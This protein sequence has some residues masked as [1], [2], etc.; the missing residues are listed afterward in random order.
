MEVDR[1]SV[2]YGGLVAVNELSFTA[3]EEQVT[4]VLGPNGAGKTS[5]IE[6]LEGFRQPSSGTVRVSGLDPR[7]DRAQLNRVIGVMLQGG[8]LYTAIRPLEALQL[9]ASYYDSPRDPAEL[10]RQVGLA[11]RARTPWR[12][13]SGG[14][15]QRLS[16][17][18]A[19]VGRPSV[20]FLDEPTAGVDVS[21]RQLI[22][23]LVR[24][25][26][27][28]GVT[29]ILTTHDLAEVEAVAD[30]IVIVDNGAVV[31]DGTP[32]EVL[33]GAESDQF[34]FRAPEGLDLAA[35][36]ETLTGTITEYEPG[37]YRVERAPTPRTI[38]ALASWLADRDVLLGDLQGG[39]QRLEEVFLKLTS[40]ST[41]GRLDVAAPKSRRRRRS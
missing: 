13:L 36:G 19:I 31:A 38:A 30:R 23:D 14:E 35:L 39:R 6:C 27:N 32:D 25:L 40:D 4:V 21:G 15:Q 26:A 12:S 37:S 5:T 10:L 24:S 3:D 16:F 34:T 1:L 2:T 28:D 17:A 33:A 20:V 18:L 29:V 41:D 7:R 8:R 22:R 11:P 9:F